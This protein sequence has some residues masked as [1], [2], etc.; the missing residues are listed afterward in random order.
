MKNLTDSLYEHFTRLVPEK[1]VS[2]WDVVDRYV[3]KLYGARFRSYNCGEIVEIE[4]PDGNHHSFKNG[5]TEKVIE[6]LEELGTVGVRLRVAS[7]KIREEIKKAN[8]CLEN[9]RKSGWFEDMHSV[10]CES[11]QHQLK[12][13]TEFADSLHYSAQ[14]YDLIAEKC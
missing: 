9:V 12:A 10:Q 14:T 7:A 5:Q 4:T 13:L 8:E 3:R 6:F 2:A 11:I 1:N